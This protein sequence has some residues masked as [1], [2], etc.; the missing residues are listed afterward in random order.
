[1]GEMGHFGQIDP[2][3]TLGMSLRSDRVR[4]FAPQQ[5]DAVCHKPTHALQQNSIVN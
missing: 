3:P 1:M 4:T 5:I 2:L